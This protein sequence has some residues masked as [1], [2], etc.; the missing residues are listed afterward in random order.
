MGKRS[1]R[2]HERPLAPAVVREWHQEL[3]WGVLDSSETPGGCWV[4]VSDIRARGYPSIDPGQPVWMA[5]EAAQQDGFAFR[6]TE[7]QLT[8]DPAGRIPP[9]PPSPNHGAYSSS[10]VI[11]LEDGTVLSDDEAM[12]FIERHQRG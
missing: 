1:R 8:G 11:T 7:V 4:H 6:A 3:G 9:S 10:L 5:F 2:T 12:A